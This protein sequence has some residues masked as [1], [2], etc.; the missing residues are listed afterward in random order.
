MP[1]WEE[2]WHGARG[3]SGGRALDGDAYSWQWCVCCVCCAR[4]IALVWGGRRASG[5]VVWGLLQCQASLSR[6]LRCFR[7]LFLA[8][9]VCVCVCRP[10]LGR[11]RRVNEMSE[12]AARDAWV[13][14]K[15]WGKGRHGS[16]SPR[17]TGG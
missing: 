15:V 5:A 16:P 17:A 14:P 3:W 11:S 9:C 6:P 1:A 13:K 10:C 8:P 7:P 12:T 4:L 2:E